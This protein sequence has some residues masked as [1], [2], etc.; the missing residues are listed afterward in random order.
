MPP[1]LPRRGRC[2]GR[3]GRSQIDPSSVT[4]ILG[5]F[6][7]PLMFRVCA[8]LAAAASLALIVS[9]PALA[10]PLKADSSVSKQSLAVGDFAE[11]VISVTLDPGWHVNSNNPKLD[12]LIPTQLDFELPPGMSV[13]NVVYPE[14]VGRTLKFLPDQELDL[15]EGTFE[16]RATLAYDSLSAPSQPVALLR[17]QA[18]DDKVCLRPSMVRILLELETMGPN[19]R[20]ARERQTLQVA[21]GEGAAVGLRW[22][23]F[24][25]EA[26]DAARQSRA[27]FVVEFAAD[28]CAP[29]KE[30]QRSTFR[31]ADVVE[32]GSGMT[33]LSVDM[34]DPDDYVSRVLRSFDVI[35]APTT[36]FFDS[37]GKEFHRKGGFI[38]PEEFA[39]LLRDSWKRDTG[40]PSPEGAKPI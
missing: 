37:A 34:T 9:G 16:I 30:M 23:P 6:E 5:T 11:V 32:A 26:Y 19:G 4:F 29:C 38:G 20:A 39:Q 33:F 3:T 1:F 21:A 10:G 22:I 2:I 13:V 28:W 12:F 18:C 40:P 36:V 24:S 27:P 15:Y 14:P 31:D 35:A 7:A 8:R 17:Y 25:T